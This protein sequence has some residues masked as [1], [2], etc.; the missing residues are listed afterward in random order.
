[1]FFLEGDGKAILYT[2]DVRA[3]SWWVKQ[4]AADPVLL[5][6]VTEM[7]PL[8]RI[9]LDTTFATKEDIHRQFPS[10]LEGLQ[11]LLEEVKK[12]P[13]DTK[14]H[15]DPWTFGY[16]EVWIALA[17]AMNCQIHVD[18]YRFELY[19]GLIKGDV[20]REAAALCGFKFG[21]RHHSGCLTQDPASR[22]HSCERGTL[23]PVFGDNQ[24]VV[25]ILPIISRSS[26]GIE[27]N[28]RGAGGRSND[29]KQSH[30]LELTDV[31]SVKKLMSICA[32]TIRDPIKLTKTLDLLNSAISS[33]D[34]NTLAPT[35]RRSVVLERDTKP[36][37]AVLDDMPLQTFV[38]IFAE[39]VEANEQVLS[40]PLNLLT[41]E[42]SMGQGD[43]AKL[44]DVIVRSFTLFSQSMGRS[45]K[46]LLRDLT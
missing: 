2:G 17:S 5:P 29:L 9:Y 19:N 42:G 7:K 14:F 28:E 8:N 26:D 25:R 6:Y 10:K 37:L 21:N 35:A 30:E 27:V 23:C 4:L 34:G 24:K 33:G 3:E 44:P 18:R 38:S 12:Y 22:I 40:Q 20:S 46:R 39:V 36:G 31:E 32:S 45:Q 13:T 1:M 43:A 11:E 16:E 15:F 41:W